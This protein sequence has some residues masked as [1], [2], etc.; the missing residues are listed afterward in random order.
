MAEWV[1][2][3]SFQRDSVKMPAVITEGVQGSV[4]WR[5]D[6]QKRKHCQESQKKVPITEL[7]AAEGPAERT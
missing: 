4:G 5:L 6:R 3:L 1:S 2:C 7:V